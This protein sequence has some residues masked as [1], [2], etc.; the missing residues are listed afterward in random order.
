[1]QEN[2]KKFKRPYKKVRREDMEIPGNSMAVKVVNGNIE[3]ALKAF[4]RKIK[5]SGKMDEVKARKEY[6][7]PSAIKRK[8]KE[9]AIRAQWRRNQFEN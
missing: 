3:L 5:D 1:M 2:E 9:D 7:K 8:Q 4:K 6:I